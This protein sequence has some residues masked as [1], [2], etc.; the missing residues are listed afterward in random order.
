MDVEIERRFLVDGRGKKPWRDAEYIEIL[1]CYLSDVIHN[2]GEIIWK[3]QKLAEDEREITNITTW[4]IRRIVGDSG[5]KGI[6]TAKGR[7]VGATAPEYEWG[8]SPDIFNELN[9]EGLPT[10]TKTRFLWNG[11]DGLLWEVDEFEGRLSGLIIAEVELDSESQEVV[12]PPWVGLELTH[13]R[14]WSNASLST[15]I[16]DAEQN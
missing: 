4:R 13:L 15:M 3:G 8:L 6:L 7:R 12:L 16:K 5:V 11:E 2:D 1:Q 14:G 9:L 10:I